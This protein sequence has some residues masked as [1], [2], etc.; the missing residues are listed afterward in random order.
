MMS[1]HLTSM[2]EQLGNFT[3]N[4][5]THNSKIVKEKDNK[6]SANHVGP[7]GGGGGNQQASPSHKHAQPPP[8]LKKP[9]KLRNVA[10][11]AESYDTLYG[12][13]SL[14][15]S[16]QRSRFRLFSETVSLFSDNAPIFDTSVV[17]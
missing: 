11:R 5:L 10:S 6:A 17:I 1:Q 4:N 7:G 2:F 3:K 13:G 8:P 12:N 15:E 9:C 16:S 14:F